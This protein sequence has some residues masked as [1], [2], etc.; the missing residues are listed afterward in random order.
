PGKHLIFGSEMKVLWAA[1][2]PRKYDEKMLYNFLT[3]QLVENPEDVSQTFFKDCLRLPPAHYVVFNVASYTIS[4]IK[5]YWDIDPAIQDYEI[6][7]D[8]VEE[9]LRSL[10]ETSVR[11]RLRSDVPVGSSLSGGLDSSIV[12]WQIDK[13]LKGSGAQKTFSARFP[14]FAKDEGAYMQ[15]IIDQINVDP[16]FVYPDGKKMADDID[17]LFYH[18]EEPFLSA[19]I[20]AQYCVMQLAKQ[21]NVTVLL[22][23]QGADE[24]LAGYHSYYMEFF[25]EIKKNNTAL[26]KSEYISYRNLQHPN[27]LNKPLKKDLTFLL[28]TFMPSAV[29][30]IKK[31]NAYN[32]QL[33]NRFLDKDFY[34]ENRKNDFLLVEQYDHLNM[35]L[36]DSTTRGVLQQLLRYADRNSMAHSREVRLPFLSHELV[37][38]IFSLPP[39]FKIKNGWTK[40]ILRESYKNV[41]PQK[42]CWRTDKV[43]YE[44]PQSKW[45]KSKDIVEKIH[46][47]KKKLIDESI[48]NKKF[49]NKELL[50]ADIWP[51]LMS[52]YLIN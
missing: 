33:I 45:L 26:Y 38:F 20:Y 49:I 11:R 15:M 13:I 44:P 51:V 31:I 35:A 52:G 23:G 6:K 32:R 48:I 21:N 19:S 10:F 4:A 5:R 43:G 18:Q 41:L 16:Y 36:Y 8:E 46:Q 37:S 50:P 39:Y 22:D 12:V 40:W 1:G 2:I 34:Y 47:S 42:I 25:K 29:Q 30:R 3:H 24:V 17:K 14:G 28:K 27:T 7:Q 9:R